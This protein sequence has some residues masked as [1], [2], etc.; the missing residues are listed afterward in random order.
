MLA[1][2]CSKPGPSTSSSSLAT[3]DSLRPSPP[4]KKTPSETIPA[5]KPSLVID[6]TN[7][8]VVKTEIR[9]GLCRVAW[10]V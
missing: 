9:G 4:M 5:E 7:V 8:R 10:G 6:Q 2:A 1:I 3:P